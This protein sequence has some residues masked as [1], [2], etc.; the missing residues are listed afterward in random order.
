[1]RGTHKQPG[2]F[3]SSQNWIGAGNVPLEKA[4]FVPPPPAEM[5]SS[6]SNLERFLHDETSLPVLIHSGVAHAQFETIH[7]FLDGNG[8]IGRLLITFLLVHRGVLRQ[9]L[10][11]LSTFLKR[12]RAEYYERLTAIREQGD[13]EGWLRFFLKGVA[14]TADEATTTARAIVRLREEHRGLIQDRGLGM[15]ELKLLD[16]LFHVPLVNVRYIEEKLGVTYFTANKLVRQF[17]ALGLLDEVTGGKRNR[18]FR[19]SPYLRLFDNPDSVQDDEPVQTT[20]PQ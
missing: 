19:Y 5:Q 12:N 14:E 8:R 9:P 1:V 2:E 11:Y 17:E 7:P 3:R 20:A 16:L 6:L 18:Q 10:L 15:N 4:V 13:W